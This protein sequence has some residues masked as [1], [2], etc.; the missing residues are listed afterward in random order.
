[1]FG[2]ALLA[3]V[4][5]AA[6]AGPERRALVYTLAVGLPSEA[7]WIS[8]ADGRRPRRLVAGWGGRISPDGRWVAYQRCHR[9]GPRCRSTSPDVWLVPATGGEPR[10]LSH[11]TW[12]LAWSPDSRRIVGQRGKS[13]VRIEP[14][15]ADV[16]VLD[17]G[18]FAGVA[19]SP[20]GGSV[21]Y[22]RARPGGCGGRTDVYVTRLDD[23]GRRKLTTRGDNAS[24]VWGRP[25][26]AFS[27]VSRACVAAVWRMRPDGSD[28]RRVAPG[29]REYPG[30]AAYG[31]YPYA[32]FPDGRRLL[33][34]VRTEWGDYAGVLGVRT[35]AIR[36][37]GPQVDALS[38][39]GRFVLGTDAGVEYPWSIEIVRVADGRRRVIARGRL[40]CANWNR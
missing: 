9:T 19:F 22:A 20:D 10:L 15:N 21:V 31:A 5:S 28:A 14:A 3:V 16:F 11:W 12:I 6:A 23:A 35:R 1:V 18:R 36:L 34:G 25:G 37:L 27:R 29:P 33:V 17:R 38:R 4:V 13:L 2:L 30:G 32:W 24:P 8:D 40:C 39:D 26:I 7:V